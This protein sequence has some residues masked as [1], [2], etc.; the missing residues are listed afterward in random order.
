M[1]STTYLISNQNRSLIK[2]KQFC[3]GVKKYLLFFN[4]QCGLVHSE[5]LP[6]FPFKIDI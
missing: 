2:R 1:K 3:Y 5:L 4:P 6:D